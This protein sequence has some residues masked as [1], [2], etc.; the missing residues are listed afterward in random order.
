[1]LSRSYLAS[2]DYIRVYRGSRLTHASLWPLESTELF[3]IT[4]G[5]EI[6][7]IDALNQASNEIAIAPNSS[8][9]KVVLRMGSVMQIGGK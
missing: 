8:A 6:V 2:F 1:M 7:E 5:P 4:S 9:A 3:P